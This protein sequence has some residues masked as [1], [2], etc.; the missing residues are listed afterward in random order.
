M[1]GLRK[2]LTPFAPDQS[3]AVAVL[4]ELGGIVVV[5]DAG[6]C[7]GNICGFDEPRWFA[8][9][10]AVFSAGLRD[11]DAILGRDDKLVDELVD[12]A[13]KIDAHFAAIV[14]TPVPSVIGTDYR[15]L[16]RMAERRGS[17]PTITVD[18]TGMAL[19]DVGAEKAYRA[20]FE[21][22]A[23]EAL[24]IEPGRVGV[25][26]ANP[27]ELSTTTA[28]ALRA[29]VPGAVC[30]GM[31]TGFADVCAASTAERNL[32][33]APSGLSTARL[34]R[35]RFGTPY[36]VCDPLAPALAERVVAEADVAGKRV[37]VIHQ[38]VTAT[39]LRRELLA[40]GAAE[41]TCATWFLQ[42]RELAE[43]G[44]VRLVEEDDLAE[45]VAAGAFDVL[46]G[47]PT[48]WPIVAGCGAATV[49]VPQFAVSG[50]LGEQA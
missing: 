16:R 5:C 10:S 33:V 27:L 19:Y 17:L 13:E 41:V 12:A 6:G 2:Y 50:M 24:P 15:A 28:E 31:G 32:V 44:D 49:D 40:R 9:R 34:L 42:L 29:C 4:F 14:G 26:G 18:T 11:M 30:Y 45:L 7:T 20:L 39:S 23:T 25:L 38:Q 46:V 22:F 43:P 37:L 1:R 35:E 3:G 48:L 47:D 21:R 8:T 36:E